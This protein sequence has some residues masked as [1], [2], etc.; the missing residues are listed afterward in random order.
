MKQWEERDDE[1]T[2]LLRRTGTPRGGD[3]EVSSRQ[4]E[5][6]REKEK[7]KPAAGNSAHLRAAIGIS[8]KH[9]EE[10]K[11]ASGAGEVSEHPVGPG[12]Q[13]TMREGT[14]ARP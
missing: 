7:K 8:P 12:S 13:A 11:R 2:V 10:R 6:L 5:L 3:V 4:R 1:T 9:P 14:R